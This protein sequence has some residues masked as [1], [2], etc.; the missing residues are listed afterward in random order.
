MTAAH[1]LR[2]TPR[3]LTDLEIAQHVAAGDESTFELLMRRCNQ[4]MYRTARAILGNDEDAEEAVQD[5]YLHAYRAFGAYRGDARLSSWLVRIVANQARARRREDPGR[6][7]IVP[8]RGGLDA[9]DVDAEAGMRNADA[10]QARA[11]RV[12]MRR[13]LEARI[14]ALPE[15]FRVVFALQA[16]EALSVEAT[17]SAL[18]IPAAEVRTRFFRAR[19]R[20][21]E[22]L[23][24]EID[25]AFENAFA[26]GGARC[27]RMVANV[28]RR[29]HAGDADLH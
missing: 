26:F 24:R 15:A 17:A 2:Q 5:A 7:D 18:D 3:E 25:N 16:P 20:L 1:V 10:A 12:E 11:D 19:T 4:M 14:D 9:R 28:L 13:L 22:A 27:D 23:S 21:R 29:L 8:I 6:A